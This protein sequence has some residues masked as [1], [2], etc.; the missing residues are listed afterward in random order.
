MEAKNYQ[1]NQLINKYNLCI[2]QTILNLIIPV[3]CYLLI[4]NIAAIQFYFYLAAGTFHIYLPITEIVR[5]AMRNE[6]VDNQ[7]GH[8]Q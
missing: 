1:I 2:Y 8:E 6:K 5:L 7:V 3:L 4:I